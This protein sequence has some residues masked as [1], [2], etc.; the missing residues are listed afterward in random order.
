MP[1]FAAA[2]T[3][4]VGKVFVQHLAGG[5]SLLDFKLK[6]IRARSTT[7]TARHALIVRRRKPRRRV[8]FR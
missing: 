8:R 5:G 6:E 4:A 2:S 7:P 1:G 3:Y